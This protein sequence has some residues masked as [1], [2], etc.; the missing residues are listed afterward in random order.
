MA[1]MVVGTSP[2]P[3]RAGAP[4]GSAAAR[5]L[6][7]ATLAFALCFSV[8]GL[9]A[10]L[11]KKFEQDLGLT[12]TETLFL[13][14]VPVILGSLFRIPMG[15]LTDRHGGRRMFA[16]LLALS[17]LPAV[18]FGYAQSYWALVAVGF[19]LGIAGSSFAVGIPFVA[20]WYREERQGF[21]LGVYGMGNIGTAVAALSA[22]AVVSAF[23]RPALGWATATILLTAAAGFGALARDAPRKAPPTRYREVLRSGMRLW[24]LA[25]FY[26]VTFGGFVAMALL[27]PKLLSDWFDYSLVEAGLRAAGFTIAATLTRPVGGWLADRVGAYPVL[28]LCFAG[29]AVD[30]AVLATLA[31]EPRIVPITIA[32][33]SLACFLGAG[34]GAVFKLVPAEFPHDAGA[35][36][37][38]VGA[39]GGLGGFFPPIFMGIVKDATGT[40]TIGFVGLLIATAVCLVAAVWLLRTAPAPELRGLRAADARGTSPLSALDGEGGPP[41]LDSGDPLF[42]VDRDLTI[43]TWNPAVERL[44]GVSAGEAVGRP[45]WEVLEGV[46]PEGLSVCHAGCS[47]ARGLWAGQPVESPELLVATTRGRRRVSLSTVGVRHAGQPLLVHTMRELSAARPD[48]TQPDARREVALSPRQHEVLELLDEGLRARDIAL[49]LGISETTVRNHVRA[50]LRRLGCHSQLEAVA[51]ARRRGIIG[52]DSS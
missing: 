38:L 50:I 27:L 19:L 3:A 45:C 17:A 22:P 30:A 24:R 33:L 52:G 9:I 44:T 34:N 32:C 8:W 21:A 15:A 6:A 25:F 7:L 11:A 5:N 49:R 47:H 31:P 39:A 29:I 20:G 41:R 43:V 46:D 4:A 37:G 16:A 35:A 2:H 1:G 10:P 51:E 42:A 12:S 36:A 40:Y 13:T 23:G 48:A 28:V 18:L 14:A 26:F